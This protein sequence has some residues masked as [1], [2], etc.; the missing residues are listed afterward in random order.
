LPL[1]VRCRVE[2]RRLIDAD[3]CRSA[4]AKVVGELRQQLRVDAVERERHLVEDGVTGRHQ[5]AGDGQR[6]AVDALPVRLDEGGAQAGPGWRAREGRAGRVAATLQSRRT[7]YHLEGRTGRV[8][9]QQRPVEEGAPRV[10]EEGG[11]LV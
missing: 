2:A 1:P 5:A 10:V 11:R 7:G 8:S 3:A 9:R 4:K 6:P